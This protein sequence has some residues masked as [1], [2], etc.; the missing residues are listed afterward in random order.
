MN[1][2]SIPT[3]KRILLVLLSLC[4]L[5]AFCFLIYALVYAAPESVYKKN[6]FIIGLLFISIGRITMNVY[7]SIKNKHSL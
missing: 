3:N 2:K 7:N 5:V 4:G 6:A 1:F